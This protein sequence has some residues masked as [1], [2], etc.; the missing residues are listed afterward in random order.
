M[1]F[2][3]TDLKLMRLQQGCQFMT[4][5]SIVF[6]AFNGYRRNFSNV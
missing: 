6:M 2:F 5:V 1:C 4:F 3:F